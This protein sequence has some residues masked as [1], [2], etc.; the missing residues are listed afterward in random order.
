MSRQLTNEFRQQVEFE[1][2]ID[3][4]LRRM[5]EAGEVEVVGFNEAGDALYALTKK[6]VRRARWRI[7]R[8]K[9][10]GWIGGP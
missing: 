6:G 4:E 2:A 8:H 3:L 5:I 7:W 9:L 10:F 1:R